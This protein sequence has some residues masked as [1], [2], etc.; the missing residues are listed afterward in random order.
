MPNINIIVFFINC[1]IMPAI[2]NGVLYFYSLNKSTNKENL[3][4][5]LFPI[6]STISY[7]ISSLFISKTGKFE[8]FME[9]NEINTGSVHI[10]INDNLFSISQIIYIFI[11]YFALLFIIKKIRGGKNDSYKGRKY[12]EEI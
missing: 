4:L 2:Y 1:Y 12:K 8:L 5:V 11:L 7:S 9:K 6:L 3:Y 10:K